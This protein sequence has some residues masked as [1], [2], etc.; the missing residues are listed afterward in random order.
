MGVNP[1]AV[2]AAGAARVAA[3]STASVVEIF[4]S[5]LSCPDSLK[6]KTLLGSAGIKFTE[7]DCSSSEHV[8]Y[9]PMWTRA[10]K[11]SVRMAPSRLYQRQSM[12]Q[13]ALTPDQPRPIA[14]TFGQTGLFFD[15]GAL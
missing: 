11:N 9:A 12:P 4:S 14:L 2:S 7:H 5:H 3:A 15:V 10:Y 13:A 6:T 1:L 8:Q